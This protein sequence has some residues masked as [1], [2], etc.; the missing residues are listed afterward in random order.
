M[1]LEIYLCPATPVKE[2]LKR[3]LN[4]EDHELLKGSVPQPADWLRAWRRLKEGVSFRSSARLSKTE[5]FGQA[6]SPSMDRKSAKA[7]REIIVE[8]KRE[9]KRQWLRAASSIAICVDD[10]N[11]Y[12]ILK[13]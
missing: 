12:K 2:L 11:A 4:M 13:F 5:K 9:N 3:E 6:S 10:R 7:L 8:D 1:A